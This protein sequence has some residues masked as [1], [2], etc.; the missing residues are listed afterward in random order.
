[1]SQEFCL[2]TQSV[3]NNQLKEFGLK[4]CFVKHKYKRAL[5]MYLGQLHARP[6]LFAEDTISRPILEFLLSAVSSF[7]NHFT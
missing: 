7:T 5:D 6:T 1:M 2:V 4:E 3:A